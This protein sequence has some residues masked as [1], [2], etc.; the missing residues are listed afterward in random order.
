MWKNRADR[1]RREI[2]ALAADGMEVVDLYRAALGL[3]RQS[4][5]FD[6][7]CWAG[8]DP[9]TLVMNSVTELAALASHRRVRGPLRPVRI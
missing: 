5:P 1:A 9:E 2:A 7:A 4:V 3:V 8:V 6:Q